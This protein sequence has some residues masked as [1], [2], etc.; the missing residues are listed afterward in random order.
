MAE[1]VIIT[2]SGKCFWGKC[3][4][5]P[6]GQREKGRKSCEELKREVEEK[7]KKCKEKMSFD[8]ERKVLKFFNSG[9]FL[10]EN[11]IPAEFRKALID[12]AKEHG[13]NS[14]VVEVVPQFVIEKREEVCSLIKYALNQGVELWFA[15]G[16]EAA[17]DDILAKINKPFRIKHFVE[18]CKIIRSCGGKVR[19]YLMV[20]LPFVEDDVALLAKSLAFCKD[21]A[22]KAVIINTY[23]RPGTALFKLWL[24]GKWH[25]ISRREFEERVKKAL[26]LSGV[27][28]DFVEKYYEDY[29]CPP[30]IPKKEREFLKGVGREYLLHPHFNVWHDYIVKV[31]E[32]PSFKKFAL[33]LPC[34]YRKPYSKS[35]THR[36]ILR[37]LVQ[38]PSYARIHQI[39][40]SNAGVVPREFENEYPFNS[41]DWEEWKETEEVQKEYCE[42]T[43]QRLENYMREKKDSYVLWFAYLKPD[44]LSYRALMDAARAAG[45]EIVD[46]VDHKIYSRIKGTYGKHVLTHPELL[47]CMM[48]KIKECIEKRPDFGDEKG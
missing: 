41:Y 11:Q 22:D 29:V 34:S 45:V 21:H 36:A 38:L 2:Y 48:K 42:V 8:D 46:C 23:A 37:K 15:M 19:T 12:I 3:I 44:S 7:I 35:A 39:M 28:E 24:E 1:C 13:F 5:C 30:R 18:A 4:F 32:P 40:I 10:D 47:D 27:C 33:F 25:P 31:Y 20:N 16:L 14:V 26:E 43:R 9:S 17:D 6:F